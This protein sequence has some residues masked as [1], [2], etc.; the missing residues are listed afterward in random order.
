MERFDLIIIGG[1]AGAF[2]A[3]TRASELG[4]KTVLINSGLPLGG[5]CVNVGCVP[6]KLLLEIGSE[7]YYPQHIRFKAAEPVKCGHPGPLDFQAAIGEKDEIVNTLRESNYTRVAEG[8]GFSVMEGRASFTSPQQ[9][10]VN[11][12]VLEADKFIIATGSR[13]RILPFKGIDSVRYITNREAL[14]LSRLPESMIVI[15][16]GPVGLEFAQ[17][18]ARFGTRVTVLEKEVQVLPLAE[19]EV[20]DELQRCLEEEGIEI[21]TGADVEEVGE[22]GGLKVVQAKLGGP[23][24]PLRGRSCCWPP[25]WPPTAI[26]WASRQPE[27]RWTRGVL[28]K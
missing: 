11:G 2:A 3:A 20:A 9:V 14:S 4:V 1:G 7:Y 28:L 25:E 17:M 5:T 12:Q 24:S 23:K 13:P 8:L 26:I 22:E 18:Y 16:A 27:W 19:R 15:G 6:S 21:H 10:E